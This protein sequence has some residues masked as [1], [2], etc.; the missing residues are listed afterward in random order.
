MN[1][2]SE[3]H[4]AATVL[5]ITGELTSDEADSFQRNVRETVENFSSNVIIDCAGL[6]L[7]DSVGLESL[8]WLSDELHRNGN[9]LRFA[10]VSQTVQR[11]FELTRLDRVFNTHE[12]VEAAARSFA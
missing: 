2:T 12:T 9:K 5:T 6:E 7:I 3:S 11:V 1:I 10:A 8:L 4:L